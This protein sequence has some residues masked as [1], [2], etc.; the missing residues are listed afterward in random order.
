MNLKF[1]V[2]ENEFNKIEMM[3]YIIYFMIVLKGK[4]KR[5]IRMVMNILV[6]FEKEYMIRK[7]VVEINIFLR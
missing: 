7:I 1:K 6:Y 5:L 3:V 2:I 4:R